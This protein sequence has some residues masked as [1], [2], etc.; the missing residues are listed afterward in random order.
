MAD[1]VFY[2]SRSLLPS[3]LQYACTLPLINSSSVALLSG[4]LLATTPLPSEPYPIS[5]SKGVRD[6]LFGSA[7][8]RGL[9]RAQTEALSKSVITEVAPHCKQW[10]KPSGGEVLSAVRRVGRE[11]LHASCSGPVQSQA[12][13]SCVAKQWLMADAY[14]ACQHPPV[15]YIAIVAKA[16]Q[17]TSKS[18]RSKH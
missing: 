10:G 5:C 7:P 1:K 17:K 14:L 16:Q 9:L 2:R 4:L 12:F 6:I 8:C 18:G 13:K 11:R 3:F 15:L